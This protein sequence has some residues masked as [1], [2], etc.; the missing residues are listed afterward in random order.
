MTAPSAHLPP[1]RATDS[2]TTA[3]LLAQLSRRLAEQVGHHEQD[4]RLV[5]QDTA[6]EAFSAG[7]SRL[8]VLAA[9]LPVAAG[10]ILQ[11]SH[12]LQQAAEL[13]GP[14]EELAHRVLPLLEAAGEYSPMATL[15]LRQVQA[16][17][18]LIDFMC[19]REIDTLCT[20]LTPEPVQSLADFRDLPAAAIHEHQMTQAP[21]EIRELAAAH[22]DLRLLETGDGTLVAAL[23]DIDS[24]D[25]VT[26][27][28]AGVGSS[29]PAGWSTQVARARAVAGATGGASVL[30][31]GYRAPDS[32][33]HGI[34]GAPARQAGVQLQQFQRALADRRP[35]QHRTVIGYSYGSVVL[36]A[37]ADASGPG[38]AADTAILLGSPGAGVHRAEQ[39]NLQAGPAA[40]GDVS[41]VIAVTGTRDVVGLTA[42]ALG[43]VH[44]V[45]PTTPGFGAEVWPSG[46][47]HSGYWDDPQ[48]LAQLG[49]LSPPT[50]NQ[51]RPEGDSL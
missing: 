26:T 20:D 30:W 12:V 24:A 18:E 11:A 45:D 37:A 2:A 25:S 27:I 10:E 22:P 36:G 32:V 34:T 39:L 4:W 44:G 40:E 9:P 28:A 46:A 47:D 43:G 31:L 14:W 49:G 35:G 33:T 48:F 7:F 15:I 23:G 41:R 21:P 6:G 3:E 17:G 42:T 8:P 16:A 19:A 13:L 1:L 5:A 51:N 29:D 50:W 38:L